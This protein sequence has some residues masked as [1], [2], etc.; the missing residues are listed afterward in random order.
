MN[1]VRNATIVPCAVSD[2]TGLSSF[3]LGQDNARGKLDSGGGQP[4]A[5]LSC[6]D[7]VVAYEVVPSLVKI[8]VEGAEMV[9]LKGAENLLSNHKP[10]ILLS[11]H[12]EALRVGCLEFLK[13]MKY[14]QV[15][16]LNSHEIDRASEFAIYSLG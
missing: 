4:V 2:S 13:G 8:D 1:S 5:A 10:I 11:T 6:D 12:G 3:A 16:P 7:F 15:V 14:D 9:V